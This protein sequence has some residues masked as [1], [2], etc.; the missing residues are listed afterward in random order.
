MLK[1]WIFEI[2]H[3]VKDSIKVTYTASLRMAMRYTVSNDNAS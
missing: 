3:S 2:L 1:Q